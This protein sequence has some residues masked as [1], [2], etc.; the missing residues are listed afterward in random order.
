VNKRIDVAALLAMVGTLY[1][2]PDRNHMGRCL[3]RLG[4]HSLFFL[5]QRQQGGVAAGGGG[6]G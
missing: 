4:G 2:L 1:P 3:G 6:V 5:L